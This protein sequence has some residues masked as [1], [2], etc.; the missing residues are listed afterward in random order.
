MDKALLKKSLTLIG[1]LLGILGLV[2]VLYT[3]FQEYT[4]ESFIAK[5]SS[6]LPLLPFLLLLNILSILLGIYAWHLMLIQYAKAPFDF[7]ISYYHFG[8]TEIAKYLPGNV[9]HFIGR[10]AIASKVGISQSQMAKT[11]VLFS[12][13]L[14]VG[15][16]IASTLTAL[17]AKG[18]PLYIE[19]LMLLA[20]FITFVGTL[21]LYKSFPLITKIK[22]NLLFSLSVLFQGIMLG[23]IVTY[24]SEVFESGLFF[25]TVSIYIVSWLIGFITPGAS[26]GLGIREGTFIAIG[27]FLH[28]ALSTEVIVFS[29]LLVRLVNIL[30][31]ILLF[32]STFMLESK[33]NPHINSQK[34]S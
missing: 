10:Q 30:V 31:D 23:V 20:T 11:S 29:V 8:K 14:L 27:S 1:K 32:G 22:M 34:R 24:Q 18:I 16:V 9:F 5:F 2:F 26:G 25:Q 28:L 12:L 17:L 7:F 4:L 13:L 33:I 15:T 6:I 19:L 21:L 3:L